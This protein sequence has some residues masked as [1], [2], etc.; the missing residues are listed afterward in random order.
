MSAARKSPQPT[1]ITPGQRRDE[2]VSI[3][4]AGLVRLIQACQAPAGASADRMGGMPADALAS[5]PA[6]KLAD[7][8]ETG[9]EFSRET[10]L[11]VPA[12]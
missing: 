5:M 8:S 11:S 3:L 10:R 12:G 6:E 2:I 1:E 4:A 7:S 9:L